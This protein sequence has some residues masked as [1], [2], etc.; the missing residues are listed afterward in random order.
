MESH[1]V[2][3]CPSQVQGWPKQTSALHLVSFGIPGR[4]GY[5]HTGLLL[6]GPSSPNGS[7]RPSRH[8]SASRGV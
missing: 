4:K 7:L 6:L 1:G 2:T 5:K 3:T 8:L